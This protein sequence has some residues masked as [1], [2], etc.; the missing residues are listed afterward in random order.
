M[1]ILE[2]I[3]EEGML[4]KGVCLIDDSEEKIEILKEVL[5]TR[6]EETKL[7]ITVFNTEAIFKIQECLPTLNIEFFLDIT[8]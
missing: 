5:K 2:K 1:E 6:G 4:F 3:E 7:D 8:C